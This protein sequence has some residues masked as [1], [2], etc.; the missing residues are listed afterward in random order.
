[1]ESGEVNVFLG[2]QKLL[3]SIKGDTD[4]ILYPLSF[5]LIIPVEDK[6]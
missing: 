4:N 6:A 2:L 3:S 1:M 5:P